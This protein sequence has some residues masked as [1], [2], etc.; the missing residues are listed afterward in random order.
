MVTERS[1]QIKP[2]NCP[3]ILH[4]LPDRRVPF[5][6]QE[7]HGQIRGDLLQKHFQKVRDSL[8]VFQGMPKEERPTFHE[9]RGLGGALY[10]QQGFSKEYVNL[11][12]GHTSQ[13]MTDGYT[14][15]HQQW[16][17]CAADLFR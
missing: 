15:P 8:P 1:R 9:I 16:T 3:F 2:A 12:M 10:L 17:E 14:D 13:R 7:H 11:L 4:R 6:G 5:A